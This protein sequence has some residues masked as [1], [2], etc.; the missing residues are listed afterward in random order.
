MYQCW[1]LVKL[2]I[3]YNTMCFRGAPPNPEK[4]KKKQRIREKIWTCVFPTE[5]RNKGGL[6]PGRAYNSFLCSFLLN[7][8]S[9]ILL[10]KPQHPFLNASIRFFA[11]EFIYI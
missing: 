8:S 2:S 1:D 9:A 3:L 5:A 11:Q 6:L 7:F 10:R 4:I